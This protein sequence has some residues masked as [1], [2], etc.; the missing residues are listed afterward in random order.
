MS[1]NQ[2]HEKKSTAGAFL[3]V[4]TMAVDDIPLIMP[5]ETQS[6]PT[7]WS[8]LSYKSDLLK[9][10][11]SHY[12]VIRNIATWCD[13][14]PLLAYG[15]YWILGDEAHVSTIASHP[16]LRRCKLGE[17]L[18]V[19]LVTDARR[20]GAFEVTLEVR[21]SNEAAIGLYRS[22][23]FEDVGLRK[24]YYS[25]TADWPAEDA[26]LLTLFRLDE[27]RIWLPLVHRL[28]AVEAVA[29]SRLRVHC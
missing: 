6:F 16:D 15:G 19:V 26:L 12:W 24:Q 10:D 14:P 17:W 23:G 21:V 2:P 29:Q 8:P 13:L 11:L 9:N 22:L 7:P 18:M 27:G 3:A 1:L 5:L 4:D 25:S 20:R 28:A